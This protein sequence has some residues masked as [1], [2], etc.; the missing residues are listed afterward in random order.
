MT[1]RMSQ[2]LFPLAPSDCVLP[3]YCACQADAASH[4]GQWAPPREMSYSER[5]PNKVTR[6]NNRPASQ[7]E[8]R[9]LR[10]G[11]LVVERHERYHG[12]AAVAQFYR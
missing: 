11:A 4:T 5:T 9:R 6:A 2:L 12:E 1:P 10:Q 3:A 8:S 7:F